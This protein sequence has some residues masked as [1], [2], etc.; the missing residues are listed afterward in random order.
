MIFN[1]KIPFFYADFKKNQMIFLFFK[2]E[3][4]FLEQLF[5]FVIILC[6]YKC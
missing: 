5:N 1:Q 3:M 4:D 6:F 2:F